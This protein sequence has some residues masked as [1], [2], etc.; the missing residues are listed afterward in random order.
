ML[1]AAFAAIALVL[2]AA[3]IFGV[4]SYAVSRR[5]H[6]IGIRIALGAQR[7]DVHRLVIGQGLGTALSGAAA[8]FAA[9][10]LLTRLMRSLLYGVGSTDPTTFL[11][12]GLVLAVVA[13][14]A[15]WIPARR[16]TRIDPLEAIRHE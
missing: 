6:E 8:G 3:G 13:L 2:A 16:A 15:S 7:V 9:A 10:L 1:L 4:M 14:V 5:T 12:V 11:L